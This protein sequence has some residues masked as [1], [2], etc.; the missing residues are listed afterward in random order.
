MIIRLVDPEGDHPRPA[1]DAAFD[2]LARDMPLKIRPADSMPER[3]FPLRSV[4]SCYLL[5]CDDGYD[6]PRMLIAGRQCT[7]DV[8]KRPPNFD[9]AQ[10]APPM[11]E[12]TSLGSGSSGNALLI[13]TAEAALL[14]DCGVGV[15]RMARTLESNGLG[16]DSVD[17]LLI[18]HE[19]VDHVREAHRFAALGTTTLSSRG[20]ALAARLPQR[21]WQEAK[22]GQALQV[23]GVD[24]VA[25]P[26]SHDASEPCG[27]FIRTSGGAV[28][29]L[30]DLGSASSFAA[31]V[32]AESHLVVLEANHD[33]DMLRRGP[34]PVHL[35]RRILSDSGHLSN[36][37]CASLLV[38]ALQG[39]HRL[40]TV[41]LAHLSETNNRPHLAAQT[42]RRRLSQIGIKLELQALPR[43]EASSTWRLESA[44][45]GSAQ[46]MFD[47]SAAISE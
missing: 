3:P 19:H 31:E 20:T 2:P 10:P 46:L 40:P 5:T 16:L 42:V 9:N 38:S 30:T 18:S 43:R 36:E 39:S 29:V 27:F 35:Q 22:A 41:W 8:M 12:V 24:V 32:I 47:F 26:V 13:R 37:A 45:K 1:P 6:P 14:V 33:V 11:L 17:A 34:Y 44:K 7:L 21:N 28:T 15:R 23:A 25:I 4:A